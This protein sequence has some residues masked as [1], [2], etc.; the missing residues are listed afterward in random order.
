MKSGGNRK[1]A[2]E[3]KR[4]TGHDGNS[5]HAGP[6]DKET[7][8]MHEEKLNANGIIEFFPPERLKIRVDGFRH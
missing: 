8:Q 5:T 6:D 1:H 2:D 4:H 3:V 7:S